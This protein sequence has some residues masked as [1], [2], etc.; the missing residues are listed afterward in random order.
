MRSASASIGG[1]LSYAGALIMSSYQLDCRDFRW[2]SVASGGASLSTI[3][4]GRQKLGS[5]LHSSCSS[6]PRPRR[7]RC[8][9]GI[10]STVL[11]RH[12][13]Y[14]CRTLTGEAPDATTT[15]NHESGGVSKRWFLVRSV[16]VRVSKTLQC[17]RLCCF[18]CTLTTGNVA[19][20]SGKNEKVVAKTSDAS[21]L[22]YCRSFQSP[23]S[24]EKRVH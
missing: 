7:T 19:S 6:L 10:P 8:S 17:L 5:K 16:R 15:T 21:D 22:Y 13:C 11:D 3:A 9:F 18:S 23:T 2:T 20:R 4:A 12:V 14:Q 24:V 1:A